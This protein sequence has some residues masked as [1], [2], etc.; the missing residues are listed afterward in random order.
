MAHLGLESIE[1]SRNHDSLKSTYITFEF[2][3]VFFFLGHDA[4]RKSIF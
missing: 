2:H 3:M 1:K 4:G